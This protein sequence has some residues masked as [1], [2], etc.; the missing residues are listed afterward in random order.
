MVLFSPLLNFPFGHSIQGKSLKILSLDAELSSD[1]LDLSIRS[2]KT[3]DCFKSHHIVL[4]S[5]GYA[6]LCIV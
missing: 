6:V 5:G 4:E 2:Q 1:P 3:R